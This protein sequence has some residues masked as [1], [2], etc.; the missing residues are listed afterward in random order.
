MMKRYAT[1][2]SVHAG[3]GKRR[4]KKVF[5][6]H[7]PL[8]LE[9]KHGRL[10]D[11]RVRQSVTLAFPAPATSFSHLSVCSAKLSTIFSEAKITKDASSF[12]D[13]KHTGGKL[14][15]SSFLW[16]REMKCKSSQ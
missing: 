12:S 5:F 4:Q 1:A 10:H 6:L 9:T 15:T 16:R 11:G 7:L 8:M 13:I 2:S 3:E 14:K